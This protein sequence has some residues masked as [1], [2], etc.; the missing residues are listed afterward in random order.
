MPSPF[1]LSH[2][3]NEIQKPSLEKILEGAGDLPPVSPLISSPLHHTAAQGSIL[4]QINWLGRL[5]IQLLLL[6]AVIN[7][8]E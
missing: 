5:G 8:R 1:L 2:F 4:G 3:R 7:T 6:T